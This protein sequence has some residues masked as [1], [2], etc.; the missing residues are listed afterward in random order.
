VGK[1]EEEAVVVVV[2]VEVVEVHGREGCSCHPVRIS[3]HREALVSL[4]DLHQDNA[5]HKRM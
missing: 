1:T 4:A 3:P 5:P 2:V